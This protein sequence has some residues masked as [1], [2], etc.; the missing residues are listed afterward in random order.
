[1]FEL[2]DFVCYSDRH[3]VLSDRS[4]GKVIE[5]RRM[6]SGTGRAYQFMVYWSDGTWDWYSPIWLEKIEKRLDKQ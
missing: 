1:M 5:I 3:V 4:I 2:G 6:K